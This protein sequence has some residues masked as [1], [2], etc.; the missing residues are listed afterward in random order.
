MDSFEH[1]VATIFDRE[2]YWV[3]TNVKVALTAD[4]RRQINR[5]SAPRWELDVV[6]YS[7][8]R[9]ELL[10]IE[11]KSYLDSRGVR[12]SSFDGTKAD[13]ETRYKLFSDE[14]LR[15]TVLARLEAQLLEQGFCPPGVEATLCLAAGKIYDDPARLRSIFEQ[16]GW[17]LF[18][19]VRLVERLQRLAEES[20]DSSIASVVAKLL[21]REEGKARSQERPPSKRPPP[22]STKRQG[23]QPGLPL[24]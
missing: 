9:S 11:C 7:G 13:A 5:P 2:G 1:V 17:L 23:G 15:R 22:Y 16:N 19:S 3:R 4:E 10:V 24:T 21:L 6:A 18:D 14:V 8:R 20:Y 12:T